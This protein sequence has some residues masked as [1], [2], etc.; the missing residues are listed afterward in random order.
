MRNEVV[1]SQALSRLLRLATRNDRPAGSK[2]WSRSLGFGAQ[3]AGDLDWRSALAALAPVSFLTIAGVWI[4]PIIKGPNLAVLY[5]LAVVFT[6]LRWGRWAAVLSAI[7]GALLF[8]Y[9]F[10][11]PYRSFSLSDVWYLITLIGL[12]SVGLLVSMLTLAAREE[13]AAARAREVQTAAL[14]SLTK[15][16]AAENDLDQILR[17]IGQHMFETFQ[18]PIMMWMPGDGGLAIR[19]CN[20][21][22]APNEVTRVAA[23][24]VFESGQ[25][26]GYGTARFSDSRV[27]CLPLKTWRAVEGVL[28]VRV[29]N[30][31]EWLAPQLRPL[32]ETFANQAALAITRAVLA[33]EA[34]RIE[35]IQEADKLQK[36][37]LNSI[38]HNLRTPLSSV[39]GA[40]N[41]VLE[42]GTLLDVSTQ[43]ELLKTAQEEARRLNQLLQNLLDMTRLEGGILHLKTELHDI[44]D[45]VGAALEQLAT[46]AQQ[47]P[48]TISIPPN[49]PLVRM[50]FVPIV[51]VLVN[52]LDN[53]LKYSPV[54]APIEVGAALDANQVQIRVADSGKGIPEQYL[55]RVFEK[56]F[57]G[58]PAEAPG[59]AGLGLS[60]CK[61]LVEAHHGRIWAQRREQG[62]TEVIFSLPL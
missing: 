41:S 7:S 61:G 23:E 40:L 28:G 11:P 10:V 46:V 3:W 31:K 57:R 36:A 29:D 42:D 43:R 20:E 2:H 21:E 34:Q 9:F 6:A 55:Q 16:L 58:A 15:S 8:D 59:G 22:F 25:V 32:L 19:Y 33:K 51:Q 54:D 14:Y 17:V 52:L 62:G 53:A 48:I 39:T 47:R 27:Y 13:A 12:L 35:V 50:D 24:W 37:L 38:S 49:L 44:Q 4:E 45:A 56:F 5:M 1:D 26:A 18:T 30:A 60:I